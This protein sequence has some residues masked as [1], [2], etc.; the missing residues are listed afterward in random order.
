MN[1]IELAY[2]IHERK[3]DL[4]RGLPLSEFVPDGDPRIAAPFGRPI[5]MPP[6]HWRVSRDVMQALTAASP[7]PYP[8]D[9]PKTS[10]G[11]TK[12]LLGWPV[13]V[14]PDA[15]LGTLSLL[16][17]DG[18]AIDVG[19]GGRVR[20]SRPFTRA[21]EGEPP[22]RAGDRV[23]LDDGWWRVTLVAVIDRSGGWVEYTPEGSDGRLLCD[24]GHTFDLGEV[25][26]ETR[27]PRG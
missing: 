8:V 9:N 18:A 15:A 1:I 3:C 14:D 25:V 22:H 24:L 12:L 4:W 17:S 13:E 2:A 26:F 6:H 20:Q 10:H 16:V 19:R 5:T 27:W 21:F 7:P 11:A 23:E